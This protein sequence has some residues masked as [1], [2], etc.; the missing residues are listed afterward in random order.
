MELFGDLATYLII[1]I[2]LY[3]LLFYYMYVGE[4]GRK[5]IQRGAKLLATYTTNLYIMS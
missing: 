2:H 1:C 5:C 3:A 4:M